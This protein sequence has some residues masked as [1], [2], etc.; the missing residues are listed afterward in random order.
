M[1]RL[2][3]VVLGFVF[4]LLTACGARTAS[5]EEA[6]MAP[7]TADMAMSAPVGAGAPAEMAV[8]SEKAFVDGQ[9]GGAESANP[10]LFDRKIIK[11]G[12]MTLEVDDV[13]DTLDQITLLAT[14]Y[15]G[16]MVASRTWYEGEYA[17]AQLTLAV[18]VDQFEQAVA[19]ARRL[20]KVLDEAISSEDVTDQYVD[21]EARIQN[22]EATAARIRAFL[23]EA[24]TVE[25]A[26]RVNA[27]LSRVEAELERLKGQR[28][29]LEKRTAFSTL[30]VTL[31]P[32]LPTPIVE[33][34]GW[35]P[36][37]TVREAWRTLTHLGRG[38]VD[39]AIWLLV[40]GGPIVLL[41]GAVGFVGWRG[42]RALWRLVRMRKPASPPLSPP[43]VE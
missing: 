26:L 35:S 9:E 20:G 10:L 5:F 40:V 27:E 15:G 31:Q 22:L 43:A 38:V 8:A 16:Y 23:D 41:V 42:L 18:P 7:E 21:L 11:T 37:Q 24:Q 2:S 28:Q 19:Q 6:R 33:E 3:T 30:Q 17:Y 1:K 25:E 13:F 36:M 39:A 14:H 12:S 29:A 34:N 32:A 4:V